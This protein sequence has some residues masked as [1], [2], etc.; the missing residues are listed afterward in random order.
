MFK[1][2]Y[3]TTSSMLTQNRQLNV[4]SNNLSN[5]ETAGYKSDQFVSGTFKDVMFAQTANNATGAIQPNLGKVSMIT[6][7]YETI[8]NF[9][10]GG[11][12]ET[13]SALDFA[14][15]EK[16]FF[17][18]QGN[19]GN[20]YTRNGSFIIDDQ[21]Y[22]A[23]KNVGR[24]MGE[25]GL[26]Q[27]PTDDF[28]VDQTG[29]LLDT[30]NKVLGKIRI[31]DFQDYQ[32]NLKKVGEGLFQATGQGTP[33][34]GTVVWKSLE[35][36]NVVPMKEMTEM[37]NSQRVLQSAAQVLKIYDQLASRAATELGRV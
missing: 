6:T 7:P 19:G 22:L 5:V 1:G 27:L 32:T 36:S 11:W 31:V 21:G 20:V 34:G 10:A 23:M 13:G 30:K 3:T 25:D 33:T 26:I 16:G 2:F 37:M 12:E 8:T 18:I 15:K 29:R 24:V 14:V 4:I 35:T 9:Q 17:E 28:H